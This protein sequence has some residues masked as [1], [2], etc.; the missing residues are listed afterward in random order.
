VRLPDKQPPHKVY[1]G[2][3]GGC[4]AQ[5]ARSVFDFVHHPHAFERHRNIYPR[6]TV[7]DA[8]AL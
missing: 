6:Q 2:A 3:A 1:A 4:A 8:N 7:S 5:G